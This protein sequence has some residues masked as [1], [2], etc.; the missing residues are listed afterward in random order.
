MD[1]TLE[2]GPIESQEPTRNT[3]VREEVTQ[4]PPE[5][6]KLVP[7]SWLSQ[8]TD[9]FLQEGGALYEPGPSI[10]IGTLDIG[11]VA[12]KRLYCEHNFSSAF[13]SVNVLTRDPRERR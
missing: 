11:G 3:K 1:T 10:P 9:E 2:V 8:E 13:S 6:I 7:W 4:S 12:P 5:L